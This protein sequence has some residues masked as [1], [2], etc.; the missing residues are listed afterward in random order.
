MEVDI[1]ALQDQRKDQESFKC[2]RI[3]SSSTL[4]LKKNEDTFEFDDGA[5]SK[6]GKVAILGDPFAMHQLRQK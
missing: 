5:Q 6:T 3:K 4:Q 1:M 2:F